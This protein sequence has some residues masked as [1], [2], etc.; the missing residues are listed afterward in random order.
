MMNLELLWWA[1]KNGGDSKFFDMAVSHSDHMIRDC[2][3]PDGSSYHLIDYSPENGTVLSKS[4]TPQGKPGGVWSRGQAWAIYGF[5]VSY[6]YSGYERYLE[7]AQKAADYF[8]SH[9]PSDHV[10]YWDFF[11]PGESRDSSAAA[12][13]ASAFI[14]LSNYVKE[15]KAS[16]YKTAALNII[17]SLSND[18]LGKPD[19][20]DAVIV[21]G[22]VGDGTG[23]DVSLPYAD[24][25]FSEALQRWTKLK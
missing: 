18:Y 20:T 19:K 3:K 6:R 11:A 10:P 16:D 23:I 2:I 17:N 15:P 24:F 25:Y 14:E 8:I 22:T 9:L 5:T 7:T 1:S 4:N 21:H 12:I 13:A